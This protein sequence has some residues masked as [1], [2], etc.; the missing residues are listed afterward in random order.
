M[1]FFN[2][3]ET[4]PHIKQKTSQKK[5]RHQKEK[6]HDRVERDVTL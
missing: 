1:A 6:L 2:R 5:I 3:S 4:V